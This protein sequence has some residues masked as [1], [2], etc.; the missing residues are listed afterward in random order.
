MVLTSGHVIGDPTKAGIKFRLSFQDGTVAEAEVVGA[1]ALYDLTLLRLVEPGTYPFTSLA[2][3]EPVPGTGVLKFGYPIEVQKAIDL[4]KGR[5]ASVRFGAVLAVKAERATESDTFV[6]DCPIDGGDSGGPFV[7]LDGRLLGIVRG[8]TAI[9]DIPLMSQYW[10]N[11]ENTRGRIWFA[12]TPSPLIRQRLARMAKG[13]FI[14]PTDAERARLDVWDMRGKN[15]I[16]YS[17]L[18]TERLWTQGE[19]TLGRFRVAVADVRR[20]VV[21]VVDGDEP[22]ALGTVVDATG[23]VL[24]KASEVPEEARCRLPDGRVAP[25]VVVGVDPACD[26]ALLRITAEELV[27]V[28]WAK[29][30]EPPVGTLVAAVGTGEL[31][32]AV[33]VV[34]VARRDVPG[35]HPSAPH[36][37][38]RPDLIASPPELTGFTAPDGGFV[39]ETSEGNAAAADIRQ[40]DVILTMAGKTVPDNS[41]LRKSPKAGLYI[42]ISGMNRYDQSYYTFQSMLPLAMSLFDEK[43]RRAGER[44]LVRLLRGDEQIELSLSLPSPKEGELGFRELMVWS[45]H[46]DTPPT[47]ITADIPV[48]HSECGAPVVGAD[49]TVLGL[50]IGRFGPTGSFIIP[51]DVVAARLDDLKEGK[52]LSGFSTPAADADEVKRQSANKRKGTDAPST[53]DER[54]DESDRRSNVLIIGASSLT[55]PVPL[56]QLVGAMLESKGIDMHIEGEYPHLDEV[57]RLLSS[58]PVWDFVVMDAWH[59]GR[60]SADGSQGNAS[61]PPDFP[62]AVADFHSRGNGSRGHRF[63]TAIGRTPGLD[64]RRLKAT[65]RGACRVRWHV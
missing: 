38:R 41:W 2:E 4:Q 52:P 63:S 33:G 57:P 42:P 49:G 36:R 24:T 61:V 47:V 34:S 19:A 17:D 10:H 53:S 23:L 11:L 46:H 40:G 30:A 22:T 37:Y 13:E 39:V 7:D 25:A 64:V 55:S 54:A 9:R 16:L 29:A 56:T 26:L 65:A 20:S 44:V 31:P 27:P 35:P 6:T 51:A 48:Y 62:K 58:Q 43:G 1:D 50:V 15:P 45:K 5:P 21:E 14:Q 32:V 12:A 60:G 8:V 59:L 18:I 28:A 3:H